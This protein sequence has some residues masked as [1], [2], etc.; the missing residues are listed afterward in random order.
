MRSLHF[1]VDKHRWREA[2]VKWVY[3]EHIP[4]RAVDSKYY[5]N[6]IMTANPSIKSF[7]V[8]RKALRQWIKRDCDVARQQVKYR[9]AQTKSKIHLS[10]DV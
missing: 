5:R 2:L 6:M 9:L 10:F 1:S 4:F 7:L 3:M 8:K